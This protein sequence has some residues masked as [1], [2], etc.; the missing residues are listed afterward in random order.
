MAKK[1][2]D[3]TLYRVLQ[4]ECLFSI[5]Q[6]LLGCGDRYPEIK[7]LNGMAT[8]ILLPGQRIRIPMDNPVEVGSSTVGTK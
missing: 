5:A 7:A 4:G 1:R 2:K 3:S 8:D 6:K